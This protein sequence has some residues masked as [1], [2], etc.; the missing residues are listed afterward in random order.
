MMFNRFTQR[1]QKVLATRT[2][3]SDPDETRIHRHRAYFAR[4]YT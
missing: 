2:R 3:R 1:A 4:T